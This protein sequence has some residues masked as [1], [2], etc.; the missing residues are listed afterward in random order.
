MFYWIFY[1]YFFLLFVCF[2]YLY[3]QSC[4]CLSQVNLMFWLCMSAGSTLK[5][6]I[7]PSI[8]LLNPGLT[9]NHYFYTQ[10]MKL[11]K[12]DLLYAK[13]TVWTQTYMHP[14]SFTIVWFGPHM[15]KCF[16]E[17]ETVFFI[18][19]CMSL[20]CLHG[21]LLE[22]GVSSASFALVAPPS[23]PLLSFYTICVSLSI[24]LLALRWWSAFRFAD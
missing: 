15:F 3:K 24:P 2:F 23:S 20:F 6:A 17:R 1:F 22:H 16:L 19:L 12:P 4:F 14:Q 8:Y 7:H 11:L 18:L 13:L 5:G 9:N 21:N 10:F